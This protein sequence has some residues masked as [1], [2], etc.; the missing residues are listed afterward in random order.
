MSHEGKG[1]SV[2]NMINFEERVPYSVE[3]DASE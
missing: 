3:K 2:G 1:V